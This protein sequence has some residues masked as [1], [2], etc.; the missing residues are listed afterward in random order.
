MILNFSNLSH[1]TPSAL[2]LTLTGAAVVSKGLA[3]VTISG[4]VLSYSPTS[5]E[6][7]S[8]GSGLITAQ[9]KLTASGTFY[10]SPI[11]QLDANDL[12][13]E[14]LTVLTLSEDVLASLDDFVTSAELATA[15][16]DYV[17]DSDLTT[18][19]A[20]YVT[21]GE[22]TTALS[23]YFKTA[24]VYNGLDKTASGFALDARQGKAL[25][26]AIALTAITGVTGGT[27]VTLNRFTGYSFL[28][29]HWV[30]F[31]ITTSASITSSAAILNGL[32]N[33]T[34][35]LKDFPLNSTTSATNANVRTNGTVHFGATTAAGSYSANFVYI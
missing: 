14:V 21:D 9:V 27:N 30:T 24:N 8:L 3:A 10:K 16:A 11:I 28:G 7:S 2:T 29:L 25:N 35:A 22:L 18:T 17:T 15:L 5:A 32:P 12:D 34:T 4:N 6:K 19:L 31:S 1:F 33:A 26:D 23:P 13:N 20:D